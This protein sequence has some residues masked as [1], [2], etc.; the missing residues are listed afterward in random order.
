MLVFDDQQLCTSSRSIT[1]QMPLLNML[2]ILHGQLQNVHAVLGVGWNSTLQ[3]Y[4]SRMC[5]VLL[6]FR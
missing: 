3:A 5:I 4:D 2:L 1:I 6:A